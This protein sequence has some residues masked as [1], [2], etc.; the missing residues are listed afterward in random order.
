[1]IKDTNLWSHHIHTN[2][3]TQTSSHT[4]VVNQSSQRETVFSTKPSQRWLFMGISVMMERLRGCRSRANYHFS[5][6]V[7]TPKRAVPCPPLSPE[8][9]PNTLWL[10]HRNLL[11][12]TNSDKEYYN[13][14]GLVA[15]L[16]FNTPTSCFHKCTRKGCDFLCPITIRT[17]SKCC[18]LERGTWFNINLY[19][20]Q[21][22]LT[23]DLWNETPEKIRTAILW[24]GQNAASPEAGY[25]ILN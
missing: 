15:Q 2:T 1:M 3:R 18:T 19:S 17:S 13:I 24:P 10:T 12:C 21:Q 11:N 20:R 16:G 7:L 9:G 23:F 5:W 25:L 22:S 4:V 6:A 8:V 14:R